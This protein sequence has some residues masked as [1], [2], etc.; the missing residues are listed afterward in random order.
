MCEWKPA[1]LA[2]ARAKT[3]WLLLHRQL[4][5]SRSRLTSPAGGLTS[6][7]PLMADKVVGPGPAGQQ[8][9]TFGPKAARRASMRLSGPPLETPGHLFSLDVK[10]KQV[11]GLWESNKT[12]KP[13]LV[14]DREN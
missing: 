13:G 11:S 12:S 7:T 2:S 4:A 10:R 3:P 9:G 8:M 5:A 1:A 14:K 6:N